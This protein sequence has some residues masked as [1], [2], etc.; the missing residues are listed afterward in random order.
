M[1]AGLLLAKYLLDLLWRVE[2]LIEIALN[3]LGVSTGV[4]RGVDVVDHG[5]VEI[6]IVIHICYLCYWLL[7]D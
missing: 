7:A 5:T 3:L 2:L 1:W 4:C 6:D